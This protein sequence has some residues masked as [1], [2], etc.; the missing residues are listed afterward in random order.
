M[1]TESTVPPTTVTVTTV[2]TAEDATKPSLSKATSGS[3]EPLTGIPHKD[4]EAP[5]IEKLE[6][7]D[8]STPKDK[9]NTVLFIMM[10][11]GIGSLIAWNVF[12]TIAPIYFQKYKLE[13]VIP[14]D[15]P[16]YVTNFMNLVCLCSQLPNLTVNAIGLFVEKGNLV[17]RIVASLVVVILACLFTIVF[18]FVNTSGWP[19]GFFLVTMATVI[20]LNCANGF[21]QNS[22]YGLVGS[23]PFKY[24]NAVVLG[25]N[26]CG[27]VVTVVCILTTEFIPNPAH[28]A[29][30]YFSIALVALV[31]CVISFFYLRR[32]I[33][34]LHQKALADQSAKDSGVFALSDYLTTFKQFWLPLVNVWAVFFVTLFIFPSVLLGIKPTNIDEEPFIPAKQYA[35]AI[36][37]LNF[38]LFSVVGS[39]LADK[40]QWPSPKYTWIPIFSRFAFI[41]LFF[42]CNYIPDGYRSWSPLI[43]SELVVVILIA[44]FSLSH[45]YYSALGMMY[46]PS[47]ADP[48]K[49]RIVGKMSAFILVF[50]IASGIAMSFLAKYVVS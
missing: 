12:I 33:F 6:L 44:I 9:F 32:N 24:I 8:G 30:V 40:V 28:N 7:G 50:G 43:T 26:I 37:F 39:K 5:M 46:A 21:Y 11:H 27:F 1:T 38:N 48:N 19:F 47:G 3:V 45:G 10:L 31:A 42:A 17:T 29:A 14:G 16:W 41:P 13:S 49:A 15:K 20:V 22:V 35:N 2:S 4:E 36:V 18:I 23:F 25:N 34:Y